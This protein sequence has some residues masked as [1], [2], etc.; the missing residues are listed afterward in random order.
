MKFYAINIILKLKKNIHEIDNKYYAILWAILNFINEDEKIYENIT[1]SPL[2][3]RQGSEH[4]IKMSF[5]DESIYKRFMDIL[6]PNIWWELKIDWLPFELVWYEHPNLWHIYDLEKVS[7]DIDSKYHWIKITFLSPTIV[8][9]TPIYK[10]LPNP[11]TYIFSLIN[12][13]ENI[14]WEQLFF[15][16][17]WFKNTPKV[18]NILQEMIIESWYELRSEKVFIKGGFVP[19]NVWWISYTISKQFNDPVGSLLKE[20]LPIFIK[21]ALWTWLWFW[22]RLWLWQVQWE[23]Y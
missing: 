3:H 4:I 7:Q 17:F 1:I 9:S 23:I 20:K 16:L 19:W 15:N 22:T 2:R 13:F 14:L 18:K 8:K 10:L 11:D 12:K 21:W 5:F 6:N